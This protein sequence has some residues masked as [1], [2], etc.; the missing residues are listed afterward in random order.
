MAMALARQFVPYDKTL[1]TEVERV[2]PA[3]LWSVKQDHP[4]HS[5]SITLYWEPPE[6]NQNDPRS[7]EEHSEELR[8]VLGRAVTRALPDRPFAVALSGG[9]DSSTIWAMVAQKARA[10]YR[11]AAL[12]HPISLSFP[13]MSCDESSA[14]RAIFE[15][16]HTTGDM[17]DASQISI[18]K[19]C[20]RYL[21][22][23]DE[24]YVPTL[25]H[26]ELVAEHAKLT[27]RQVLF[28]GL[29]GDEWLGGG[30]V[31]LRDAF[32]HSHPL[33]ATIGAFQ[34]LSNYGTKILPALY[35][36]LVPYGRE[37]ESPLPRYVHSRLRHRLPP[38]P[39]NLLAHTGR[40][41]QLTR[42]LI[43]HGSTFFTAAEQLAAHCGVEMRS[44][45]V[46][47]DLIELSFRLPSWRLITGGWI[48]GLMR[49]TLADGLPSTVVNNPKKTDFT[50]VVDRELPNLA[51][52]FER[53]NWCLV[54]QQ[55]VS[56]FAIDNMV[57]AARLG[58]CSG[59]THHMLQL[60]IAEQ[61]CRRLTS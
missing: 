13:G 34:V 19:Y 28:Y 2:R 53:V 16:T 18:T 43:H 52:R 50:E 32:R 30:F 42:L 58:Q 59:E 20:E 36:A 33:T 7:V 24:L 11:R 47:L 14:V 45:L 22:W 26:L 21:E 31:G 9:M 55:I 60:F 6:E 46:D 4:T 35:R 8:F 15:H 41:V 29:G 5:P 17:I 40:A 57:S 61:L 39:E 56:K 3:T 44:P 48:K 10:G 49:A 27:D 38:I 1:Y 23:I 25:Y 12:G 54:N 51:R 37:D